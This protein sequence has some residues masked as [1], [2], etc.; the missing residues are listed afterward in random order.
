MPLISAHDIA[1]HTASLSSEKGQRLLLSEASVDREPL[2]ECWVAQLKSHCGAASAVIVNNALR[3][4]ERLTQDD[5]F[6]PETAHIITQDV[7]YRDGFTLEE[8]AEMIR[9][10]TGLQAEWF[11]AGIGEGQHGFEDFLAALRASRAAPGEHLIV[12]FSL[13]SLAG[14]GTGRGHFSPVA[15]FSEADDMVFVLEVQGDEERFW[16]SPRDLYTAIETVDPVCELNRGW[17]VVRR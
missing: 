11:R 9:V 1:K 12:S 16:V 7:V 6:I 17:I 13:N 3:P 15:D 10:R 8:L 5:L 2:M 4:E 14:K